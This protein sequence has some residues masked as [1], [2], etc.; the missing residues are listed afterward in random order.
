MIPLRWKMSKTPE[1]FTTR[2]VAFQAIKVAVQFE[3]TTK[4][5]HPASGFPAKGNLYTGR[6]L[7]CFL[8]E[9][10]KSSRHSGSFFRNRHSHE[11]PPRR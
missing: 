5:K 10:G 7:V 9:M 8:M 2:T 3:E 4:V 11:H 1:R 6:S